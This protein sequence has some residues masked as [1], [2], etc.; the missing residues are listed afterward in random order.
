MSK[1]SMFG[2]RRVVGVGA[3]T[4]V[5]ALGLASMGAG[6]AAA[7]PLPS[8]EKVTVGVDDTVVKLTRTGESA[9]PVPSLANNGAGRAAE[10]SGL[11]TVQ[12]GEASGTLTTGYIVGCQ[13]DITG[14]EG[15]LSA[16]LTT[17]LSAGFSG[18]LSF[19]L[20]PG[21]AK[22]VSLGSKSF[23]GGFASVQYKRQAIDVQQCGGYAQ[24]RAFTT[25]QT[26]GNYV[27][28]STLYGAPFSL[29]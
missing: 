2:L 16:S 23:E 13:I 15:G 17:S 8:G 21:E 29:N 12:A 14:L 7:G 26:E 20:A 11:V 5:A 9:Y 3:I 27:I 24:A 18:A 1:M 22:F 28:K 19:P 4:A 6:N 10:V 25:V